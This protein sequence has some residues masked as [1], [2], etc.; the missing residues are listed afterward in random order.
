MVPCSRCPTCG[1]LIP[2]GAP[3]GVCPQCALDGALRSPPAGE[4]VRGEPAADERLGT[5][6]TSVPR[7]FG[8]YELLEEIGRGGMGV[9][10]KAHQRSLDRLVAVKLLLHGRWSEPEFARRFRL[11]AEAAAQLDHPNI[12]SIHEFGEHDGQP[13]YA[14]RF[15]EG[16]SLDRELAE[17]PLPPRRAAELVT[18]IARAVHFAHQHGVL[19]RD[20]KPH[21]V[22]VDAA[23]APHLTDFG[24]AKLLEHDSEQTQGET[25]FGSPSFMAPEQAT[26]G[27]AAITTAV[28]VYSLGAMLFMLLTGRAPFCGTSPLETLRQVVEDLPPPLRSLAPA[29]PTDLETIC[30][31]CLQKEPARRYT[32]AEALA[33]DLEHWL[34][35]EPIDARAPSLPYRAGKFVRR[36][37]FGVA[38]TATIV[39]LLC[40]G[41]ATSSVLLVRERSARR[42]AMASEHAEATLRRQADAAREAETIRTSRTARD[43]AER[44]LAEGRSADGLAWLVYAARKNPLDF[45]IAP[46]LASVLTSRN[47]FLPV[48]PALTFPSRVSN[49]QYVDAGRKVTVFCEDGTI[50]IIDCATND[51]TQTRLPAGLKS[52]GIILT[53]RVI[54]V[55]G[56]DD[57]IRVLDPPTGRI[58]RQLRFGQRIAEVYASNKN[59]P[60]VFAIL[61]DRSVILAETQT[62]RMQMLPFRIAPGKFAALSP[63][64]RWL[65][66][67]GARLEEGETWDVTTGKVRG[68]GRIG[69]PPRWGGFSPDSTRLLMVS[70]VDGTRARSRFELLSV[71]DLQ[72]L[73]G[74]GDLP[75]SEYHGNAAIAV[76]FSADS[77]WFSISSQFGQQVFETATG[78]RV[79]PFVKAGLFSA[80][81][82]S[83]REAAFVAS[84]SGFNTPL[85]VR[86]FDRWLCLAASPLDARVDLAVRDL[87][88]GLPVYPPLIH[89]GGLADAKVS[90]DGSSVMGIA[91]DGC[92]VF[93][94]LS[95]GHRLTEP[96]LLERGFDCCVAT[97]ADG[98]EFVVGRADG[99]VQRMRARLASAQPLVLPP[100][101]P[102]T[103]RMPA[104][105]LPAEKA[106]LLWLEAN[107]A[108]AFDVANG[109]A[110]PGGFPYPEPI[111]LVDP[112]T[113][114]G[115]AVRS[116]ARFMITA[117]AS[118]AWQVW[119]QNEGKVVRTVALQRAPQTRARIEFSAMG[120]LVALIA[121]DA[122]Q[123]ARIWK[124]TTGQPVGR[125]LTQATAMGTASFSPDGR[126]FASGAQDGAISIWDLSTSQ[127]LVTLSPPPIAAGATTYLGFSPDGRRIA[128]G[129]ASGVVRLWEAASGRLLAEIPRAVV[130]TFSRAG[131]RLL[132][133]RG[134]T[135]W[136]CD[137]NTGVRVSEAMSHPGVGIRSAAFSPDGRR[138]VTAAQDSTARIW[139]AATGL[140][141]SDPLM[142][143]SRVT[144][145]EFSP[146]GRFVRTEDAEGRF[147][148]WSVPPDVGEASEWLL[149]L[150]TICA[151]RRINDAGQCV[152]APEITAQIDAV[153]RSLAALPEDA[154]FCQWGR[155]IL[156]DRAERPIA[157]EFT[158][159]SAEA[160]AL[161]RQLQ[162][163]QTTALP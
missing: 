6:V 157:P 59:A 20:L 40:V 48:G 128:A 118:G 132:V 30:L 94:D 29:V 8:D 139:D 149:Q 146:D 99:T 87:I 162:G 140:P 123:T 74:P 5:P 124:L 155:W 42:R 12:V 28:D 35:H 100:R 50:G 141:I 152:D 22:L 27:K 150:A 82:M 137:A 127:R 119:E 38:A 130:A 24:L 131:D 65:L 14:M 90:D 36:H 108:T 81:L 56:D 37:R 34:H 52:P 76:G 126:L 104:P 85:M 121:R 116:D 117:T 51:V 45:T 86:T 113:G 96:V 129:N 95:T 142:H 11:E 73:G 9:V 10:Y 160:D 17:R 49:L 2:T 111:Q 19:H 112:A 159:T 135:A 122:P 64:A 69:G 89:V 18:T 57:V 21:N 101:F 114:L 158:I 109:K 125:P 143:G 33:N 53:G 145:C 68:F 103:I 63:D 61:E 78:A 161:A 3:R 60:V 153:R 88:T 154:P 70:W 25:V 83:D 44:L 1:A 79:G 46:R 15:V 23:G 13:Y 107:R 110:A 93:W 47:F 66:R 134:D 4:I 71:P 115:L 43:L 106:R 156:D 41:F 39:L 144:A 136:V 91:M 120:D 67:S 105:F 16:R 84:G 32:S 55:R 133:R 147:L 97:S 58:E 75:E 151:Q 163:A 92:A 31:K 54:V 138:V 7:P 98:R 72:P 148:L 80:A 102:R 77:R 26:A 62:G